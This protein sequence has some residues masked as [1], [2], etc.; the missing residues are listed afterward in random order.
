MTVVLKGQNGTL[1]GTI[2]DGKTGKPVSGAA[3]EVLNGE[4]VIGTYSSN[5]KGEYI[6]SIPAGSYTLRGVC[7]RLR[8]SDNSLRH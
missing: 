7:L 4:E 3:I 2:T 1:E 6:A 8:D 5:A